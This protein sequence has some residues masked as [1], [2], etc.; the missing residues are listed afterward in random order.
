MQYVADNNGV[1]LSVSFG[2]AI[3]CEGRS[4]KEYTGPVPA[5]YDSLEAWHVAVEENLRG[6][7]IVDGELRPGPS[8]PEVSGNRYIES[9]TAEI[10]YKQAPTETTVRFSRTYTV[11]PAVFVSCPFSSVPLCVQNEDITTTLFTARLQGGFNESGT[12]SFNWLAIGLA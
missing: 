8:V 6:W 5:G 3:E 7:F 9:G 11:P 2:A 1:L 12:R 10:E 4:C